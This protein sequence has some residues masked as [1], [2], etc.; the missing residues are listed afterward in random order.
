ML[1]HFPKLPVEVLDGIRC[2]YDLADLRGI[3]EICGQLR[4]VVPPGGDRGRIFAAPFFVQVIQ[5]AECDLFCVCLVD[6]GKIFHEGLDIL[7]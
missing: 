3:F 1:C 7:V 5:G 2:I 4:P 6:K